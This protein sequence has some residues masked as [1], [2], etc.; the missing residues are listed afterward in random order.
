MYFEGQ[1]K[2]YL[3]HIQSSG[4]NKPPLFS[5]AFFPIDANSFELGFEL[6]RSDAIAIE[7]YVN[8]C[9]ENVLTSMRTT[10]IMRTSS[11]IT[12]W[13]TI[14][15]IISIIIIVVTHFRS[16]RLPSRRNNVCLSVRT[17]QRHT[18]I[19]FVVAQRQIIMECQKNSRKILQLSLKF[20]FF[21]HLS[22]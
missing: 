5:A 9:L 3:L 12:W 15:I 2:N 13:S 7:L 8:L 18:H 19:Q 10:I 6:R 17:P 11:S 4:E 14:R 16:L 22:K 20:S 1:E 21:I